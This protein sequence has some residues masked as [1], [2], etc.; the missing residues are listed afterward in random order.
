MAQ[1]NIKTFE[2][3]I[4]EIKYLFEN[5][6]QFQD[7]ILIIEKKI[8]GSSKN[9]KET[10]KFIKELNKTKH[11]LKQHYEILSE[12]CIEIYNNKIKPY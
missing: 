12:K 2:N 10:K 4:S 5:I 3:D 9:L 6:I 8:K 7:E 1:F 11:K